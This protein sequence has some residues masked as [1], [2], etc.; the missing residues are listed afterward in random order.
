MSETSRKHTNPESHKDSD[1][2]LELIDAQGHVNPDAVA[3]DGTPDPDADGQLD[4]V[5]TQGNLNP[6]AV[7]ST[8]ASG[9]TAKSQEIKA[10]AGDIEAALAVEGIPMEEAVKDPA[11]FDEVLK[12]AL[13]EKVFETLGDAT[14]E[15]LRTEKDLNKII[16]DMRT[17][18]H[19]DIINDDEAFVKQF[20]DIFAKAEVA[21]QAKA[22]E[23]GVAGGEAAAGMPSD[24]AD[25]DYDELEGEASTGSLTR[26]QRFL[27]NVRYYT[28]KPWIWLAS[29][30]DKYR[31]RYNAASPEE[32]AKMERK[33]N[34]VGWLGAAAVG[35]VLYGAKATHLFGLMGGGAGHHTAGD[36]LNPDGTKKGETPLD[37]APNNEILKEYNNSDS[38][39]YDFAHKQFRGDFGPGLQA[40]PK[41]GNMPA[42]FEDWMSRNKHE[43]NGLA[44]L[45]S[46]LK[47]DG[48]GDTMADR[49]S[50]AD[51]YD[52]NR[53][54]HHKADVMVQ[55]VLRDSNKFG[56]KIINLDSYNSTLMVDNNGDPVISV[57]N[58]LNLGGQAIEITN[59]QTGEV[60]YWRIDCGGYQQVWPIEHTAPAQ[61]DYHPQGDGSSYN[62]ES[63]APVLRP[64]RP[65]NPGVPGTPGNPETPGNPGTPENPEVPGTPTVPE[66]GKD[67]SGGV[68]TA[69]GIDPSSNGFVGWTPDPAESGNGTNSPDLAPQVA[70]GTE[71]A[72]QAQ[73]AA[74]NTNPQVGTPETGAGTNRTA[75]DLNKL[76]QGGLDFLT[77]HQANSSAA[78][79]DKNMSGPGAVSDAISQAQAGMGADG[80]PKK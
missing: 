5:D 66:E 9:E 50:L 53:D 11:L 62:Y 28:S 78:D 65:G 41:D 4:L 67:Y 61:S 19:G 51:L 75:E 10:K 23:A 56:M 38:S 60:T 59:K 13:G 2:Q 35:T 33:A 1:D 30:G 27:G 20:T 79:M 7:A 34:I 64:V 47:L 77:Q 40:S 14:K 37:L 36:E 15:R 52:N 6:D 70:P 8:P 58:G 69:E 74:P 44:N 54:A 71:S 45:I 16:E 49:N 39:F 72:Q 43:P 68:D 46:G 3:G 32:K 26:R 29:R 17:K 42:G 31:D 76:V 21:A 18:G 57:K 63:P 22:L 25:Y 55:E 73:D 48:H 12:S 24:A 80:R